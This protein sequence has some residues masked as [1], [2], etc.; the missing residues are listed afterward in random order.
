MSHQKIHEVHRTL[1]RPEVVAELRRVADE[2][3]ARGQ[4]SYGQAGAVAVPDQL[5]WELEIEESKHG[6]MQL[7]LEMKWP[8]PQTQSPPTAYTSQTP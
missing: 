7:E 8:A 5:D 4:V 6:V 1:T 2:L 3:E